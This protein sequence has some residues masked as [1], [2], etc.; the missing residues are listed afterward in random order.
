MVT[1]K[2]AM[3][4]S[5]WMTRPPPWPTSLVVENVPFSKLAA[6]ALEHNRK[7]YLMAKKKPEKVKAERIFKKYSYVLI[8]PLNNRTIF[9]QF[10]GNDII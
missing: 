6:N 10:I 7:L 8:P 1:I 9:A 3:V 5:R 2:T 4:N